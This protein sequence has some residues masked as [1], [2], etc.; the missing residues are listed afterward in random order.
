MDFC[1]CFSLPGRI[2]LAAVLAVGLV[3]VAHGQG[4][5]APQAR[6][7]ASVATTNFG[8]GA[9]AVRPVPPAKRGGLEPES[10]ISVTGMIPDG[11]Y[12]LFSATVRCRAWTV[13][14]E[15][16]RKIG[17][18]FGAR[19]DYS[20]EIIPIMV[21]SQPAVSDYWGNAVSPNQQDVPGF[22]ISPVGF[23]FLYRD[24]KKIRPIFVGHL[25][26][27]AFARKALSPNASY[28]N[29]NV[30]ASAGVQ[31]AVAE[32]WDLRVEPFQFFHVSN[33]YLAASNPGMDEI[34]WKVGFTYH[35]G[36]GATGVTR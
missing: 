33:G 30:Q 1:A 9:G 7:T 3:A 29:F 2:A 28:V 31:Y 15:Y 13:G 17:H 24:H 8:G 23:R 11:D 26:A 19:L 25:G 12:R 22:S 32:R 36:R 16:D 14:V 18:L 6:G 5:E 35:L 27:A 10:E 20:T 34:G 21:L 4:P